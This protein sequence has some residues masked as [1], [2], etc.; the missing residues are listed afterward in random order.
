MG[1][2]LKKGKRIDNVDVD[3]REDR[4]YGK[5]GRGRSNSL[6]SNYR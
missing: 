5:P 3:A 2:G 4:A 6:L 1:N